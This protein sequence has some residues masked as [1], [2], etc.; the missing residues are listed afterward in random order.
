MVDHLRRKVSYTIYRKVL[1]THIVLSR[2]YVNEILQRLP[3]SQ[4]H[5]SS[6]VNCVSSVSDYASKVPKLELVADN[7]EKY[8]YDHVIFACHSDQAL[9]VL[10]VGDDIREE[11]ER[12][13]G[14]FAWN[15]NEVVL[16]SESQ[17]RSSHSPTS[18]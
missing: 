4:L 7:D 16:H 18:R 3:K 9:R 2:R 15:K 8:V 1:L 10:Q 14:A 6:R 12:I 5:L 13:L 17:V 11:E